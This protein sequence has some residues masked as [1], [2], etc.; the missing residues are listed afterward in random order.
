MAPRGSAP[1][2]ADLAERAGVSISTVSHV[3]NGT[4]FVAPQTRRAVEQAL[5][6]LGRPARAAA[7]KNR[8]VGLVT[9]AASNPYCGEIIHGVDSEAS[10][11]GFA[12]LLCDSHDDPA[13]E[14]EAVRTLVSHR[15][16]AV[17]IAPT[18]DWQSVTLPILRHHELPF[19]L[20][21]RTDDVR[22][23]QVTTE[24]QGASRALVDH[25]LEIGHRRIGMITG[26]DGISTTTERIAGY[27]EA[28]LDAQVPVDPSLIV[29]GRSTVDGGRRATETLLSHP[30]PPTGLFS[31]N[32]A[33]TI[34]VLLAVRDAGLR[35]PDDIAVVV[36]DD[37]EGAEVFS[38]PLTAVAQPFVAVGAQAF[39]LLYRRLQD[40]LAPRRLVRLPNEIEHRDSCGCHRRQR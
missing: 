10:R 31:A 17:I 11:N 7:P 14:E 4:R 18:R 30:D 32:N 37:L 40:P 16:D 27:R 36:F 15:V 28:H 3:I 12:V 13:R 2:L 34:G 35:I 5:S 39:Q 29:S 19:V 24:S 9:T 38:S 6:E 22:C 26:V 33:M 23:D 20:V 1:R 25:L 8:A 21:D